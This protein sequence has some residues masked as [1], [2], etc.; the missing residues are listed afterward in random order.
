MSFLPETRVE[1]VAQ[2]EEQ[3]PAIACAYQT[4]ALVRRIES[5]KL[6]AE[7]RSE[8]ITGST[9]QHSHAFDAP[10]EQSR[11]DHRGRV[12]GCGALSI[13]DRLA[14]ICKFL[15]SNRAYLHRRGCCTFTSRAENCIIC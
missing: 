9:A 15:T 7:L 6:G 3:I 12:G 11:R 4:D 2:C 13:Q 10:V 1:T 8:G 5:W 14:I